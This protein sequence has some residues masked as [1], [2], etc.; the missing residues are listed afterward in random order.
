[1]VL[2]VSVDDALNVEESL[3]AEESL[4]AE[5]S[6]SVRSPVAI[7]CAVIG[8]LSR[9]RFSTGTLLLRDRPTQ[10]IPYVKDGLLSHQWWCPISGILLT[11]VSDLYN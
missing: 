11:E 7:K 4:N 1:M 6:L 10:T 3:S 2:V 8:P 5:E 9:Y